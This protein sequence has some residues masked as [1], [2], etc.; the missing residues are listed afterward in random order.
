M[1]KKLGSISSTC[2]ES[3]F[4]AREFGS[5]GEDIAADFLEK[6]GFSILERNYRAGRRGEI[7]I[8]ARNGD[9]VIFVEVKRRR[10]DIFGGAFHAISPSKK[11]TLRYIASVYLTTHANLNIPGILFRFDLLSIESGSI[12]WVQDILR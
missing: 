1:R 2:S 6:K 5:G 7:D 12:E 10:S 8:I 3:M 9:L 11:K 4:N